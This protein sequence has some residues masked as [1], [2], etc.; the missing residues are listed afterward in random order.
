MIILN[1]AKTYKAFSHG[2]EADPRRNCHISLFHQ[3]FSEFQRWQALEWLGYAR[4]YEH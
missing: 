3:Q 1:Q 2:T 4:P